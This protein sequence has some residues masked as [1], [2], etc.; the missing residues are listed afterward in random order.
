M[1]D[2]LHFLGSLEGGLPGSKGGLLGTMEDGLPG[3]VEGGL[4]VLWRMVSLGLWRVVSLGIWK[5]I[6]LGPGSEWIWRIF[7]DFEGL[8]KIKF[9][10]GRVWLGV[11]FGIKLD[12]VR[13]SKAEFPKLKELVERKF[14]ERIVG[15][16]AF[17][18]IKL[19]N[20]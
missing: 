4:S 10:E 6:S 14:V 17:F 16:G 8:V 11:L 7:K 1:E 20:V 3:S 19:D 18:G 2:G 15:L 13:S 5:A 9:V 12:N